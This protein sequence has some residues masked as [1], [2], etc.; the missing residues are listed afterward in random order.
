MLYYKRRLK[1]PSRE[2]RD[3]MTHA[4]KILWTKLKNRQVLGVRFYRQ[5]P[6]LNYIVDFYAHSVKLVIECDGSQHDE[7]EHAKNDKERDEHLEKLG[8]YIL[9]FD[10]LQIIKKIDSVMEV[11]WRTV[12]LRI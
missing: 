1:P 6:L 4:E 3:N 10:N 12:T 11:I 5:K 7:I 9:R 2:L 8:I